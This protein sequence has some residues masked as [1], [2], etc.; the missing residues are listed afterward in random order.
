MPKLEAHRRGELHRA[1]S[2]FVFDGDRLL[3]Q[4][5]ADK[6]H[7]S[8]L[9]SNSCCSHPLPGESPPDAA[10]RRLFEEMGVRCDLEEAFQFTYR[11]DVPPDLIEHEYD[12]V[13]LGEW[14]GKPRPDTSEVADWRWAD[15]ET[16]ERELATDA[17]SFTPWFAIAYRQVRARRD[18]LRSV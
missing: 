15:I 7:S 10:S 3:L 1:V 4:K 9:W 2:V 6:Y 8:G 18:K 14:S 16:L 12:H 17:S 13:F 5:R 11:L